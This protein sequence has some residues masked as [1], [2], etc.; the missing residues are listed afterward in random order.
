MVTA[1]SW[2]AVGARPLTRSI[3]PFQ[4][5][6]LRSDSLTRV[7]SRPSA[8]L[9]AVYGPWRSGTR[10]APAGSNWRASSAGSVSRE[11]CWAGVYWGAA[12]SLAVSLGFLT[13]KPSDGSGAC[14]TEEPRSTIS[15]SPADWPMTR[16]ARSA[17]ERSALR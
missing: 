1:A 11:R 2:S 9:A 15:S 3:R 13:V 6:S 10:V 8:L 5:G 17:G 16:T 12:P 14:S 4:T 7:L